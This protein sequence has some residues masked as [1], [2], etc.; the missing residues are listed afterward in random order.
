MLLDVVLCKCAEMVLSRVAVDDVM[1]ES[2]RV[3][4]EGGGKGLVAA[5]ARA[6][7][8]PRPCPRSPCRP[9][10]LASTSQ[11]ADANLDQLALPARR[12]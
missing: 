6:P 4:G 3:V 8:A 11:Q 5:A 10:V 7:P 2:L 12:P 1:G 9:P